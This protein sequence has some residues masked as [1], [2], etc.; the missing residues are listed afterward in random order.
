MQTSLFILLL[1]I[2]GIACAQE[3][4]TFQELQEI[5]T[6]NNVR[7]VDQLIP[8]LPVEYR[9]NYTFMYESQ[10]AQAPSVSPDYPRAIIAGSDATFV[11]SFTKSPAV[12][13]KVDAPDTVET[14][15]WNEA[16][17]RFVM[18]ELVFNGRTAPEVSEQNPQKCL[19]CHGDD[20]RP[21]W[22]SYNLWPGAYGSLSR[23]SCDAIGVGT[24]EHNY[25]QSFLRTGRQ[26]ARYRDLP[27][28]IPTTNCTPDSSLA[29]VSNGAQT[30][31]NA[32]LTDAFIKLNTKRLNRMVANSPEYET[33]KYAIAAAGRRCGE[34][35]FEEYF[36]PEAR[37][38]GT[39]Y[40]ELATTV[41]SEVERD[42]KKI[43][44][45]FKANSSETKNSGSH[46]IVK[47]TDFM[48]NQTVTR[49]RYLM[50]RLGIPWNRVS[51][52]FEYPNSFLGPS[53]QPFSGSMLAPKDKDL[54]RMSCEELKAA[55]VN[56]T[57]DAKPC[58]PTVAISPTAGTVQELTVDANSIAT[59]ASI[60]N[61][62]TSLNACK[63]CHMVGSMGG[64]KLNLQSRETFQQQL[65]SQP[66]L[67]G[68]IR[69]Y[70]RGFKSNGD[71]VTRMPMGRP[72]FPQETQDAIARDLES[73][74]H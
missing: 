51:M 35:T 5:I 22:E 33:Y 62:M 31:M 72:A 60:T 49:Q 28:A 44:E 21:N 64:L 36:A 56:A 39:A 13:P 74:S 65:R 30:G 66:Q 12:G 58:A 71:R 6:R 11:M 2:S 61:T 16:E 26:S 43:A 24:K 8:L 70:L 52:S 54:L 18:R 23:L 69:D 40:S 53:L 57:K 45:R 14:M 7:S 68:K 4:I 73:M 27:Q 19:T 46:V 9:K 63:S 20:P 41:Q 50:E 25:Y 29:Y 47:Q 38:L 15:E 17:S 37:A 42:G 10:S 32:E 55:S 48:P 1:M 67:A 34:D 59:E 3:N